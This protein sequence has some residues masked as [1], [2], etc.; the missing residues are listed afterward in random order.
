MDKN[1]ILLSSKDEI[2]IKN[3]Q[4]SFQNRFFQYNYLDP[5]SSYC[6]TPKLISI[7][8]QFTNPACAENDDYPAF[9]A[10]PL[11]RIIEI[12]KSFNGHERIKVERVF[13]TTDDE[14]HVVNDK[15]ESNYYRWITWN[16]NRQDYKVLKEINLPLEGFYT[17]H[18]FYF[19]RKKKYKIKDLY[20]EWHKKE[21]HSRS[22][23]QDLAKE[24][25]IIK[26]D[27][28]GDILF[29]EVKIKYDD[30]EILFFHENF[31]KRIRNKKFLDL[32]TDRSWVF[33]YGH[34][35][36]NEEKYYYY[37][38]NIGRS[39]IRLN[40]DHQGLN[41]DNPQIVKI[42]CK[43]VNNILSNDSFS[44]MIGLLSIKPELINNQLHHSFKEEQFYQLHHSVNN[45][46]SIELRDEKNEKL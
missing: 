17:R 27:T 30:K 6:L 34:L 43:N 32:C 33:D 13:N 26:E 22:Q 11:S 3:N 24:D 14:F 21:Y 12:W 1:A 40:S 19:N 42:I 4:S 36:I 5:E 29:G 28:N 25:L 18:K 7:D 16:E 2:N 46:F 41:Y 39:G 45:V 38:C 44:Q 15:K 20:D 23:R 35:K 8:L 37:V 31:I 10:C 9:I